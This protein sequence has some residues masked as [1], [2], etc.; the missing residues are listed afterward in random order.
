M[1]KDGKLIICE[2]SAGGFWDWGIWKVLG[3]ATV[4]GCL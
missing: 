1:A 3:L 2:T 4:L